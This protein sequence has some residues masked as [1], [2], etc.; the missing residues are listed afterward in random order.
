MLNVRPEI[1][2]TCVPL[3]TF[4]VLQKMIREQK[5]QEC[6]LRFALGKLRRNLLNV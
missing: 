4:D 5:E 1:V 6:H 2:L 3:F